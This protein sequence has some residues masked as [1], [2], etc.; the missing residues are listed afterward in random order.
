MMR[1][2]PRR[3]PESGRADDHN[4]QPG[5][6]VKEARLLDVRQESGSVFLALDDGETLE[7]APESVPAGLPEPGEM[8]PP[9]LLDDLRLAAERKKVARLV[10]A[11]LD[12]RLHP[13]ARIRD[14]V[15]EK[16]YSP[17]AIDAVLEQ[18]A[19]RGLYSDHRY[20]EAYCRDCL[21]SRAVGRRY[22][23]SKLRGKRVPASIALEVANEILDTETEEVLA[24]RAAETRW[25]RI[26]N[27][28]DIKALA[29][30]VRFLQGR[31][32]DAGT[33]NRAARRMKPLETTLDGD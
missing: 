17:D 15:L 14:K 12:R 3:D 31:G 2:F 33:A 18:M 7:V 22:L 26:R 11:I 8:I 32:F 30:V 1:R 5:F 27:T 4:D 6:L 19:S 23:V 21:A 10:F 9:D 25:K 20:A 28:E 29:K 24:D 13:I 16:G